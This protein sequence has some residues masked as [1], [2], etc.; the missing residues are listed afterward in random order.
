VR[1]ELE[2]VELAVVAKTCGRCIVRSSAVAGNVASAS[3]AA[4]DES[5]MVRMSEVE[6]KEGKEAESRGQRE[7]GGVSSSVK[8]DK[9]RWENKNCAQ[10]GR[11][12]KRRRTREI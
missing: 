10:L 9:G 12:V 7:M 11:K 2:E 1:E 4:R 5:S 8:Q 3:K 6:A